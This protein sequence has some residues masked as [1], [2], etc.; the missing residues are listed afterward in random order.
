[1]WRCSLALLQTLVRQRTV[2]L[3]DPTLPH[4]RIIIGPLDKAGISSVSG[5]CRPHTQSNQ[6]LTMHLRRLGAPASGSRRPRSF[7]G[8]ES[9][10]SWPVEPASC[11]P[12]QTKVRQGNLSA[13]SQERTIMKRNT[14]GVD[15]VI[16]V[17]LGLAAVGAGVMFR[18]WWG[19]L[20]LIPLMTGLIG[21]C[22]LYAL[23]KVSTASHSVAQ[24]AAAKPKQA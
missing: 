4:S 22:P 16:R 15:R 10:S 5:L 17:V 2:S 14:A 3:R 13:N 11:H 23:L 7:G 20:G 8:T 6:H 12:S 24:S 21:F 19:A 18:S 9:A 1:V